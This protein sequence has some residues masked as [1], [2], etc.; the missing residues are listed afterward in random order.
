M[1]RCC[2]RGAWS[3]C[4]SAPGLCG[5]GLSPVRRVR[6]PAPA[7]GAEGARLRLACGGASLARGCGPSC[8]RALPVV[9]A[10]LWRVWRG[11]SPTATALRL[12]VPYARYVAWGGGG[13]SA[14]VV[15]RIELLTWREARRQLVARLAKRP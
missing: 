6:R 15:A 14:V 3:A 8:V 11:L 12:R 9:V 7:V 10:P 2:E 1:A 13:R 5:G 4:A